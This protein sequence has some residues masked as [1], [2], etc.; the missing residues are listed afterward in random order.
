M[1]CASFIIIT[2]V[3]V[4]CHRKEASIDSLKED[5]FVDVYIALLENDAQASGQAIVPDTTSRQN[6][7]GILEKMGVSE[8]AFRAT[9][10]SYNSEPDKWRGF[11]EKVTKRLEQR[12]QEERSEKPNP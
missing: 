5:Q 10:R 7:Q 12:A 9:V 11:Y 6:R 1:K 2:L 3:L 8:E 4:S